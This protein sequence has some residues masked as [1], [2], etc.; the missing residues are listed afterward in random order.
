MT[1]GRVA[2]NQQSLIV[3]GGGFGGIAS[4]LRA[5]A[6]GFSVTLLDRGEQLGGR[7][8]WFE[9]EGF[10]WD[11]GPTVITAPGM[12]DDLFAL[13]GQRR[14]D[15]LSFRSLDPFY[16][17]HFSDGSSFAYGGDTEQISRSVSAFSPGDVEGYR[18]L[19]AL[20][21]RIFEIGFEQL[22]HVPFHT[23]WNLV[24]QLPALLRLGA[25]RSVYSAVAQHLS[26]PRLRRAFSTSPLL[27]GGNPF[28]TTSI[29]LL[30]HALERRWGV[31]YP[32][33]GVRALVQALGRLLQDAGVEVR[34]GADVTEVE[35]DRRGRVAGVRL[36][37]GERLPASHV[38]ANGDPLTL[39]RKL[40]PESA[41]GKLQ[42]LRHKTLRHSMGLFLLYFGTRKRYPELDQ[43]NILFGR[44]FREPLEDI[45][46]N[47]RIPEDF[48]IYLHRASASDDSAAPAG[49]DSFYALVPVPHLG[50]GQNWNEQASQLRES[51]IERL[52]DR[53]LPGLGEH[54]AVDF[55]VTPED[56]GSDFQSHLGTGFSIA[57]LFHQSAWFRF[58]NRAPKV[59]GLYLVGA[60]T[61]PGAGIPGVLS[62]ARVVQRLLEES[63]GA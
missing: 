59:P 50:G 63:L 57:P 62:S 32:V 60:G 11:A 58:H 8:R 2:H 36:A 31:H 38:V 54:L 53:L 40:L 45:F 4:A 61:H 49:C 28:D 42:R 44:N 9:R 22:A 39:Y 10:C 3:I 51:I 48:S 29:Y 43:H 55:H 14:E 5:R 30:I 47:G 23:P 13:F 20:S 46:Y 33:G 24:R 26:D 12:L 15:H 25:F 16:R 17:F 35:L 7:A 52:E 37:D 6:L 34:L 19:A 21:D 27:V 1:I 41:S 56:F 18:N